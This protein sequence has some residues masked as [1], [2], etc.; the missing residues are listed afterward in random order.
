MAD[1]KANESKPPILLI[2]AYF[3]FRQ[4]RCLSLIYEYLACMELFVDGDSNSVDFSS[5]T[6]Y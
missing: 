2:I 5:M 6:E 3:P 4:V 1:A